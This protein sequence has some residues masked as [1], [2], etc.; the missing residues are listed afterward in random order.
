MEIKPNETIN[1]LI[2]DDILD[3]SNGLYNSYDDYLEQKQRI[4]EMVREYNNQCFNQNNEEY[5][6]SYYFGPIVLNEKDFN[7]IVSKK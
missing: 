4:T 2:I 6:F 5:R 1:K 3:I 7:Y